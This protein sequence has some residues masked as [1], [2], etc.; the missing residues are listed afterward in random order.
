[1]ISAFF[2]LYTCILPVS[3]SG[4]N[5]SSFQ[6][7]AIIKLFWQYVLTQEKQ[8]AASEHSS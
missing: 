8:N 3:I 5:V 4:G 7:I 2:E 1:M 6:T